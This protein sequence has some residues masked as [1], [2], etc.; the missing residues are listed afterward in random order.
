MDQT[1]LIARL[2]TGEAFDGQIPERIDTH[3]SVVFL[4]ADRAYKLKRAIRTAYLDYTSLAARK[5]GSAREIMLN[6]RTA[7]EIYLRTVP[8]T[9]GADGRLVL[10]AEGEPLDW[11]VEMNRF[12]PSATLDNLA[13]SGELDTSVLNTLADQVARLHHAA[14]V[15]DPSDFP[16]MLSQV[17]AGNETELAEGGANLFDPA[18]IAR[19]TQQHRDVLRSLGQILSE[20]A[21]KSH[22]RECH[23]DLHLGNICLFNGAPRI[24][25]AIEFNREFN[26]IDTLYDFAFLLMDLA[27]R[28]NI[29]AANLV[30][31]RYLYRNPD[32]SGMPLL[33]L[34]QSLR[35]AIRA[36]VMA[37]SG[38]QQSSPGARAE[39]LELA[40]TYFDLAG[41]VLTVS[42]PR[43]VAIGGYSGTGK[44][45]LA[46]RIAPEIGNAPGAV[47][48]S[49][50]LIRK[51]HFAVEP[52][53]RLGSR[54]YRPSVS[55]MVYDE[56]F[57]L[58]QRALTE[59]LSVIVDATFMDGAARSRIEELAKDLPVAFDGYWLTGEPRELTQRIYAR[60]QGASDAT[61]RVLQDQM[62]TGPGEIHW[63]L[64]DTTSVRD[65][66]IGT[67]RTDLG[68]PEGL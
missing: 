51:R 28:G 35:A 27:A 59:G 56:M 18:A 31:N 64:I 24:F 25:D 68:L 15:V 22:I 29:D 20:R 9:L 54:M 1:E 39:A 66:G 33:P 21:G 63:Q 53:Q 47:V 57:T 40:N 19:L 13:A 52:D 5:D 58:A 34:Y 2:A 45:T 23:G 48:L 7:P 4:T 26:V 3:I 8:V 50:D 12:D 65:G 37:K 43:L 14:P 38:P 11:L 44:S 16:A 17:I 46:S 42:P 6:R 67:V 60:P 41:S 61:A 55:R 62:E 10:G 36:H 49:S 32:F 30:F